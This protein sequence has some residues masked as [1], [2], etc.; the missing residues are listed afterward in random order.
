LAGTA[1][2]EG[3]RVESDPLAVWSVIHPREAV[4]VGSDDPSFNQDC[5]AVDYL[6]IG[7]F[8]GH[9]PGCSG[10]LWT[11]EVA[12]HA[13][14]R[15]LQRKPRENVDAVLLEA[16]HNVL[17]AVWR[18]EF[19]D[20]YYRFLV[21]AGPG[22]F[23]SSMM[24]GEDVSAANTTMFHVYAGTWLHTDALHEDQEAA[25]AAFIV[26]GDCDEIRLGQGLLLPQLLR[27]LTPCPDGITITSWAPGLPE[28][29]TPAFKKK[30]A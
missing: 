26:D 2:L 4:R 21:P 29:L 22:V 18:E 19:I 17:N 1:F 16:H 23:S 14:G 20:P 30:A 11:I 15:L 25:A 28:T 9:M 8:P 6:I 13:L 3:V 10:G 24:H 27:E 12:E 7:L 5:A